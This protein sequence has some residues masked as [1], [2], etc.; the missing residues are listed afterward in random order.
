VEEE[1]VYQR[2]I[3]MKGTMLSMAAVAALG[4]VTY[5]APMLKIT[6]VYEGLPGNDV[7]GD[8]IEISNF[9]DMPFVFGVDGELFY[10]DSSS[11]PTTD[12]RVAGIVSIAPGEA[13]VV[14]LENDPAEVGV[15]IDAWGV[16]G[17]QVGL[18]AGRQP[19]RSEP[20]WRESLPV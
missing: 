17:V 6:E 12:E 14:V 9:G 10:D 4:S 13:V 15:F 2:R 19:G 8:W 1:D 18:S 20:G 11:D 5:G 16:S 7:T 3:E